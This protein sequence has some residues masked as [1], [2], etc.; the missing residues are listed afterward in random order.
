M[1]HT[2]PRVKLF[3]WR[4]LHDRTPI[5]SYMY[6]LNIGPMSECCFC[7]LELET[8][9]HVMRGYRKTLWAWNVISWYVGVDLKAIRQL[10]RGNWITRG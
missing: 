6:Y 3:T 1:L 10:T 2:I 7:G 5:F 9:E 8:D 4:M